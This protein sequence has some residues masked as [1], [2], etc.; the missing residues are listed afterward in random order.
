M[1][2]TFFE[3]FLELPATS[4]D[5]QPQGRGFFVDLVAG[6]RRAAVVLA[7]VELGVFE[8]LGTMEQ[9]APELA[10]ALDTPV[11][12]LT[13]VLDALAALGLVTKRDCRYAST[14]FADRHLRSDGAESVASNMRFQQLIL[15]SWA[16]LAG[17]VRRGE[18]KRSLPELLG[19][20]DPGFTDAY[21]RGMHDIAQRPAALV[22][23]ALASLKPQALLDLGGGPGTFSAAL[24]GRCPGL[25]ATIVDLEATL[26]VADELHRRPQL[27]LYE[28]SYH[29]P[30]PEPI[31]APAW[32]LALLSHVT[33]NEAPLDCARLLSRVFEALAPGGH[34]AIHDFVV[35]D[36]HAGPEQGA[37]FSVNMLVYTAGGRT[38]SRTDYR[39]LLATA[40]FEVTKTVELAGVPVPSTLII[41]TK[42]KA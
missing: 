38:Y 22:A 13:V 29:D 30:L 20:Q 34:A 7:A 26:R 28:G 33:H 11:R 4:L 16:D 18:P 24:L 5:K 40:G 23:D 15:G 35:D 12:G 17:T 37:L 41:G 27:R 8:V 14:A 6:Y 32:D 19:A 42:P 21:I 9:S 10:A 39:G 3:V 25:E 1:L 31:E 2:S 36:D